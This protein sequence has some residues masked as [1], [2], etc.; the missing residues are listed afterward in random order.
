MIHVANYI[1]CIGYLKACKEIDDHWIWLG[2]SG[3]TKLIPMGVRR[4]FYMVRYEV[5][6][7]VDVKIASKCKYID[8]CG[9]YGCVNPEHLVIVG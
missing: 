1:E 7:P 5:Q 2:L 4:C 3:H 8:Y 6:L 9:R